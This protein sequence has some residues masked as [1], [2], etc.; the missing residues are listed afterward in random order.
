MFL[1]KKQSINPEIREKNQQITELMGLMTDIIIEIKKIASSTMDSSKE[2]NFISQRQSREM[3]S[4]VQTMKEF[5]NGTEET[6]HSIM[7]L[8]DRLSQTSSKSEVVQQQMSQMVVTSQQ[9][10]ESLEKTETNVNEVMDSI[11]TLTETMVAVR[12]SALKINSIIQIIDTV[13]KQTNLLALN[14]SI[15]AAR[16]G[17]QGKGFAVVAQEIRKLAGEVTKATNGIEELISQVEAVTEKA[18]N[19]TQRS[20]EKMSHVQVSAQETFMSFGSLIQSMDQ[21]QEDLIQMVEDVHSANN[22]TQDIAAITEEQLAGL[23]E[24]L[25]TS[26]NVDEMAN[27]TLKKSDIVSENSLML[28]NKS[29]ETASQIVIQMQK[30]AGTSGAYGFFFYRHNLEGVFEY[31]T[32]SVQQ[33]LGYTPEEFMTDFEKF[34]TDNPINEKGM[35]HTEFSMLGNQ[36]PKYRIELLKKNKSVCVAE[37]TEFPIFDSNGEVIAVEG[38]VSVVSD[39]K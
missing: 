27:Q 30:I 15:E 32:Q 23:E 1:S 13:A 25:A 37:I 8:S 36:Q 7:K 17:E 20:R 5:A 18:E 28:F 6:T 11:A 14:A 19:E 39:A 10:K 31:V 35:K 29:N 22:F 4:L 9:G 26:Q 34:L 38:L 21:V 24:V 33:V 3:H 12:Q 2:M 16:A